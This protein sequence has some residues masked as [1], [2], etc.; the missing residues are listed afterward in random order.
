MRHLP[1]ASGQ[2]VPRRRRQEIHDNA[3]KKSEAVCQEIFNNIAKIIS[4]SIFMGGRDAIV[5]Y[6]ELG[7][8]PPQ[9]VMSIA[10]LRTKETIWAL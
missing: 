9:E 10:G 7:K 2:S 6:G 5:I 4:T 1:E 3:R 8:V